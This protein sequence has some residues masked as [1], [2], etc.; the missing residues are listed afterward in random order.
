[1]FPSTKSI[2]VPLARKRVGFSPR[3]QTYKATVFRSEFYQSSLVSGF[4]FPLQNL[5]LLGDLV[6]SSVRCLWV[7]GFFIPSSKEHLLRS[8]VF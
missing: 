8:T 7:V 2:P 3:E 6:E 1:M 5:Y 4:L